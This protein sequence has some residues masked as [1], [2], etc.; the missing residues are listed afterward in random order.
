MHKQRKN[1]QQGE[2]MIK[3]I[4]IVMDGNRRWARERGFV[5]MSG[6]SEGAKSVKK[7]V[8]FCLKKNIRYASLYTFSLENFKRTETEKSFLFDLLVRESKTVLPELLEKEVRVR[9]V[10]DRTLFP[11]SVS[12]TCDFIE[13]KTAHLDKLTVNFL[14]CYGG[15]QEIVESA[16]KIAHKVKA[17]EL[18]EEDITDEVVAQNTWCGAI[19]DPEIIVRTGGEKRVSNFLLYQSAYS[20]FYFLDK[21]WPAI[22][23]QDLDGIYEDFTSRHRRFGK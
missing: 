15:R 3:H 21:F 13:K 23:V 22:S 4:A 10:G 7:V 20:E 18:K 16:R 17:G 12:Q 8:E 19:P 11:D 9:F 6:H 2:V 14:F 5:P 1:Y